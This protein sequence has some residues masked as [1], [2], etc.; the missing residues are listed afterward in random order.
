MSSYLNQI[1][2]RINELL[3]L[4]N[5]TEE[6]IAEL[7]TLVDGAEESDSTDTAPANFVEDDEDSDILP[8]EES[9]PPAPTEVPVEDDGDSDDEDSSSEEENN[10]VL[11]STLTPY[12][13]ASTYMTTHTSGPFTINRIQANIALDLFTATQ[14]NYSIIKYAYCHLNNNTPYVLVSITETSSK[15]NKNNKKC[16]CGSTYHTTSRSESCP[17]NK[18]TLLSI[19]HKHNIKLTK[20]NYQR[21]M[22]HIAET[23]V[24]RPIGYREFR[25]R[26]NINHYQP[27]T[28]VPAIT[29]SNDSLSKIKRKLKKYKKKHKKYKKKIENDKKYMIKN[30]LIKQTIE[31]S[32]CCD[33]K[34]IEDLYKNTCA[35]K[36]MYC[37][38][39]YDK[40][41]KTYNNRHKL[42]KKC[43]SCRSVAL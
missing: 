31:C 17:Y 16:N 38:C 30:E 25:I 19:F 8:D 35:C 6:N 29:T 18:F 41:P 5:P 40:L 7:M 11:S 43:P 13:P 10:N 21:Y 34:P 12:V 4:L 39:C 1:S 14:E 22:S 15:L 32:I 23:P 3:N 26:M 9:S 20:R 2:M 37:K 42:V 28:T 24:N 36:F 27:N 33:D